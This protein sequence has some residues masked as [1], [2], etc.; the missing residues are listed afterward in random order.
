ME[1]T[2]ITAF[3]DIAARLKD[4]TPEQI[5]ALDR[6]A[7]VEEGDVKIGVIR[8]QTSRALSIMQTMLHA[9]AEVESGLSR[10]AMTEEEFE[11]RR[12]RSIMLTEL[13]DV[14]EQLLWFQCR[15]ELGFWKEADIAIRRG[16]I[17]VDISYNEFIEE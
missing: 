10:L 3:N 13:A 9:E 12:S 14:V 16:Y 1:L 2:D 7:P 15:S 8:N 17:L 6:I 11:D 5:K 4:I